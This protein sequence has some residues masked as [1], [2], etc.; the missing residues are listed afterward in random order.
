MS[1]ERH[2]RVLLRVDPPTGAPLPDVVVAVDDVSRADAPARRVAA[3]RLRDVVVPPEGLVV[4][5]TVPE[6]LP[7]ARRFTV[8]ARAGTDADARTF[9]PGDLLSA[10]VAVDLDGT[11]DVPLAL[12]P[13]A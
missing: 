8:R 2:V 7:P 13:L 6:A 1:G 9:A 12:R 4:D 11:D 5:V 3:T 10:G